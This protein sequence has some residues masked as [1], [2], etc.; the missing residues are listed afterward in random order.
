MRRLTARQYAQA[1]WQA[2]QDAAAK[3]RPMVVTR[4][5][6]VIRRHRAKKL[7]PNIRQQLA[8]LAVTKPQAV[9]T[10][11]IPMTATAIKKNIQSVVGDVDVTTQ[12]NPAVLGGVTVR[13]GDELHDM[14]VASALHSL[15][16]HLS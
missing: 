1:L 14:S 6:A 9:V 5:Q 12:T 8:R 2:Y 11:A 16:T 4:F 15:R 7:L 13:V 10:T 3:D